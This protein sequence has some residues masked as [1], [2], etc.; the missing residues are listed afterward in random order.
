MR[1]I[2]IETGE[3]LY[4]SETGEEEVVFV[5]ASFF[6]ALKAGKIKYMAGKTIKGLSF[7][8]IETL[9]LKDK[10]FDSVFRG[11]VGS[12]IGKMVIKEEMPL[13]TIL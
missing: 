7:S 13:D 8:E 5:S 9:N 1:I 12:E 3:I 2:E 11:I 4:D 10:E 6:K